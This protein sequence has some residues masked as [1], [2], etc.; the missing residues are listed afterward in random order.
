MSRRKLRNRERGMTVML[1]AV[2][3]IFILPMVGLAID[4][5]VLYMIRNKMSAASDAAALGAARGLNV[6][7]TASDQRV[8]AEKSA[9]TFFQANFPDGYLGTTNRDLK[10]TF[11][12]DLSILTVKVKA[13]VQAPTF[14]M[15]TLSLIG[16][17]NLDFVPVAGSG[18]AT[19]RNTNLILLLDKSGSLSS[20]CTDMKN[21]ATTFVN[22]MSKEFDT[23]G[24]ITFSDTA[25]DDY[26]PDQ[27]WGN[28]GG[29]PDKISAISCGGSTATIPALNMGYEQLKKINQ[30][31][32][33]NVIVFFTDGL[34]N[35][36]PALF[37]VMTTA[38]TRYGYSGYN[39]NNAT[40]P[41]SN[42]RTYTTEC[43][44]YPKA[45]DDTKYP[46]QGITCTDS[47]LTHRAMLSQGAGGD[48]WG[49]NSTRLIGQTF[50]A[51]SNS[52]TSISQQMAS[53]CD[54]GGNG[55][56][57][58]IAYIPGVDYFGNKIYDE[59][60]GAGSFTD[61]GVAGVGG[62]RDNWLLKDGTTWVQNA[63]LY[64]TYFA[65]GHPYQKKMRPDSPSVTYI[66]GLY[67]A[68][69][70]GLRVRQDG[71]SITI[72]SIGY[73]G[74]GGTDSQALARLAND[75]TAND[76]LT[77]D[78]DSVINPKRTNQ[79]IF[80]LAATKAEL[81]AAFSSIASSVL[82]LSQ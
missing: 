58:S 16:N 11:T 70:Q 48:Y 7:G 47:T 46:P 52:Y 37:P 55:A 59:T 68:D 14:F 32:A 80:V 27:Y 77:E 24:L 4:V 3:L 23:V 62:F 71:L 64:P 2:M 50:K 57:R 65:A 12:P 79:G 44:M 67:A 45:T 28:A 53:S 51:S 6:S 49:V 1:T 42:C 22:L 39:G 63:A 36:I 21:G 72:F 35:N 82:R 76:T 18:T 66:G 31:L 69:D 81:T 73:S 17:F 75:G 78:N 40:T 15:K 33:R 56:R 19:R 41:A 10:V 74:S 9:T 20:A 54:V 30:P 34:P 60:V 8:A 25:Y 29:V 5:G 13:T 61:N 26:R 38:N 43:L